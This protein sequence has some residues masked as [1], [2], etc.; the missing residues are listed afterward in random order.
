MY[1][2]TTDSV[3]PN[4]LND[5]PLMLLN[6]GLQRVELLTR[7]VSNKSIA[8]KGGVVLPNEIWSRILELI[9]QDSGAEFCWVRPHSVQE[10]AHGN[11]LK[12]VKEILDANCD[13]GELDGE[14]EIRGYEE[15]M[16]APDRFKSDTELDLGLIRQPTYKTIEVLLP[17][18]EMSERHTFAFLFSDITVPDVIAHV[19]RGR[20]WVCGG[21]RSICPG[22]TGG[23]AQKFD[24][25][26]G[27]GVSL[28]CP[29][30]M[31]MDF[32]H[33]DK[34]WL[35][36]YYWDEPIEEEVLAREMRIKDR[37]AELGY[38]TEQE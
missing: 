1:P 32:M 19:E 10:R 28:A 12:C 37:L 16:A 18:S 35:Q 2:V 11:V 3:T 8:S 33:E 31:G 36:D 25:F 27:C 4:F 22:C 34:R 24:A 29:L 15:F 23:V 26:M 5:K 20:C 38:A 7:L 17:S 21:E 13:C 30:C 14:R 9:R 6:T